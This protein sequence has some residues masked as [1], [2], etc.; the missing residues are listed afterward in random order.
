SRP[1]AQHAIGEK[2]NLSRDPVSACRF[3]TFSRNDKPNRDMKIPCQTGV[4]VLALALVSWLNDGICAAS[5]LIAA[6]QHE[7]HN[8]NLERGRFNPA[9]PPALLVGRGADTGLDPSSPAW[10]VC[11]PPLFR[12]LWL[13]CNRA[14]GPGFAHH[15]AVSKKECVP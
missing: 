6:S 2:A 12:G 7:S 3:A 14:P 4:I 10:P 9:G 15:F 13:C 8:P 11:L 5:T 1:R